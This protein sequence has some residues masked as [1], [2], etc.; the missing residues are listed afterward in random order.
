MQASR[1]R[2]SLS[3]LGISFSQGTTSFVEF[4]APQKN[5]VV[6]ANS[7]YTIKWIAKSSISRGTIIL[8]GG[9]TS[10]SLSKIW[11]I[12]YSIDVPGGSFSW[13]VGFPTLGAQLSYFYGL[14]FSLDGSQG[15]FN[16]STPFRI[17]PTGISSSGRGGGG[18]CTSTMRLLTP[19]LAL[20]DTDPTMPMASPSSLA[21]ISKTITIFFSTSSNGN[22]YVGGGIS[23]RLSRPTTNPTPSL[24][25]GPRIGNGA[26][27]GIAV[28]AAAALAAFIGLIG[29]VLYYR[30]RLL[31]GKGSSG[32]KDSRLSNIDGKFRKAELDAEGPQV[33]ITRVYEL[34]ATRETQEADG[35]M[36]P[37]ELD[38]TILRSD[39]QATDVQ[40]DSMCTDDLGSVVSRTKVWDTK[41]DWAF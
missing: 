19:L 8:L 24:V 23:S 32:P 36:K 3:L 21:I 41:E 34:D 28:G 2:T 25:S 31:K 20:A 38:S 33:T 12:G 16:I 37:A 9:Q 39:S 35:Y 11:E 7:T 18:V 14:N 22:E 10:D 15:V 17:I 13:P 5:E 27:A 6:V 26:V 30:R 29:L 4:L 40:R 1:D